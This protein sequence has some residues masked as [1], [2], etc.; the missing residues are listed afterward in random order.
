MKGAAKEKASSFRSHRTVSKPFS[1]GLLTVCEPLRMASRN[2]EVQGRRKRCKY[3]NT[4]LFS[5]AIDLIHVDTRKELF[6]GLPGIRHVVNNK[7]QRSKLVVEEAAV[8][9]GVTQMQKTL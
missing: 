8:V 9:A 7:T 1:K 3:E 5:S 2:N 4:Y 6:D